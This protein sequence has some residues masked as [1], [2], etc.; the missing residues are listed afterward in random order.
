MDFY[1]IRHADTDPRR[2][3]DPYHVP[4]SV[5]GR[6]QAER[7]APRVGAWGLQMLCVST[8]RRDMDTA[9][10]L[11]EALPD[12]LRWDLEELEDLTLDDLNYT[13][14]AT[15][16]V[17]T[18]TDAQLQQGYISLWTRLMAAYA[19]I[20]LYATT[21][22]WDRVG[23]VAGETVL[24]LLIANWLGQDWRL[25]QEGRLSFAESPICRVTLSE[26]EPTVIAW[27]DSAAPR[28]GCA[29]APA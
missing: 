19:R 12:V 2:A 8:M 3:P 7:L 14:G 11:E 29:Q 27:L 21:R 20:L 6:E 16:L 5:C 25:L 23:I 22:G 15:H 26:G 9:D 28:A 1:L 18:W 4:L 24:N 13:P 10:P 17:S